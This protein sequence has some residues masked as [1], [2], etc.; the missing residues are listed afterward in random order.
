MGKIQLLP[1][2]KSFIC[3][4]AEHVNFVLYRREW[5][6]PLRAQPGPCSE[7]IHCAFLSC[8]NSP[9]SLMATCLRLAA[10]LTAGEMRPTLAKVHIA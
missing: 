2:I 9:C 10:S 6:L 4:V 1:S 8:L 7:D 5:H 3:F